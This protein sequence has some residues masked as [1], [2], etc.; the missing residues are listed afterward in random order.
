MNERY[1]NLYA[2]FLS[3]NIEAYLIVEHDPSLMMYT[4]LKQ[5]KTINKK[6]VNRLRKNC[7]QSRSIDQEI[8]YI[9]RV[10]LKGK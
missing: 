8:Y 7:K 1:F 4:Y 3:I 10:I 2:L 5:K 6:K 9:G